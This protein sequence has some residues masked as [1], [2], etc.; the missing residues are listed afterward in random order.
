VLRLSLYVAA[1]RRRVAGA[2]DVEVARERLDAPS[3]RAVVPV[4]LICPPRRAAK[5]FV[6]VELYHRGDDVLL[7]V[8]DSKPFVAQSC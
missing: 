5:Y 4:W 1:T 8:A 7:A 6:R 3:D 2:S